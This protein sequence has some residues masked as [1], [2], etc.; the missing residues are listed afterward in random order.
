MEESDDEHDDT[1]DNPNS[2]STNV[3]SFAALDQ[4]TSSLKAT[5]NELLVLRNRLAE[6]EKNRE[7]LME[8]LAECRSAKEKLPLFESKVKELTAENEDLLQ[9]INSLREDIAEVKELYRAQLNVLL[10]E[11]VTWNTNESH[12]T[13]EETPI[14]DDQRTVDVPKNGNI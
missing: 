2:L 3:S 9:Q 11:K 8:T 13:L 10:E 1:Y 7:E 12:D 5:K 6:S 14:D 4:L